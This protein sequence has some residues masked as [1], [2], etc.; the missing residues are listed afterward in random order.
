MPAAPLEKEEEAA[1]DAGATSSG[2]DAA[3]HTTPPSTSLRG[4]AED[5]GEAVPQLGFGLRKWRRAG[6]L[7]QQRLRPEP[8]A[9]DR[10]WKPAAST[11][12]SVGR[13]S[14]NSTGG[15][16]SRTTSP[17]AATGAGADDA[18]GTEADRGQ[19]FLN[20]GQK[21][22]G[23]YT[24]PACRMVFVRGRPEDDDLHRRYHRTLLQGIHVDHVPPS[25]R[26]ATELD[27]AGVLVLT[28]DSPKP[29]LRKV[30]RAS[31][32]HEAWRTQVLSERACWHQ[33][34]SFAHRA[35]SCCRWSTCISALCREPTCAPLAGE[36]YVEN[37]QQ[38]EPR[39]VLTRSR[40]RHCCFS[41]AVIRVPRGFGGAGRVCSGRAAT[42][43]A[44]LG[45]R[46][47]VHGHSAPA[48]EAGGLRHQPPVGARRA[49]ARWPGHA[50]A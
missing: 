32:R 19:L 16:P 6:R 5:G 28:D 23:H 7:V 31:P 40:V 43:S 36:R 4:T 38:S 44:V 21:H 26:V 35:W 15:A 29:V 47:A 33:R 37:V 42:V 30:K 46:C 3:L 27:G 2:E 17:T 22:F 39:Y 34:A 24:C 8:K 13:S 14:S 12:T 18:D 9:L 45:A 20:L 25:V 50:A 41:F 49:P 48:A 11:P 10:P 1:T